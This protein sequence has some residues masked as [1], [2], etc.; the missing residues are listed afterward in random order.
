MVPVLG[1]V[2]EWER[3]AEMQCSRCS[4]GDISRQYL[5][6][7]SPVQQYV[8]ESEALFCSFTILY[9]STLLLRQAGRQGWDYVTSPPTCANPMR[10]RAAALVSL[11]CPSSSSSDAGRIV[12]S[13]FLLL[14]LDIARLIAFKLVGAS[15]LLSIVFLVPVYVLLQPC[16]EITTTTTR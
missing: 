11:P 14:S 1:C 16:F 8:V 13:S 10:N 4:R 12:D 9:A 2:T 15:V 7:C 6:S 3:W 5:V